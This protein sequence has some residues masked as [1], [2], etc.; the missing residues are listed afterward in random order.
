MTMPSPGAADAATLDWLAH[1][2]DRVRQAAAARGARPLLAEGFGSKRSLGMPARDGTETLSMLDYT[3]VVSFD[4]TELVVVARAGTPMAEVEALLEERHQVLAFEPPRLGGTGS[5]GGMVAMGLSGPR[6]LTAGPCRDFVLGMT[7]MNSRGEM[8]R[9][10]GTVMKNVAGYDVSR[11]HTGARGSLGIILDV[12]LKVLPRPAAEASLVFEPGAL[13]A[14]ADLLRRLNG[15]LAQPWPLAATATEPDGHVFLRL[16]GAKAA[17]AEATVHF[18]GQGAALLAEPDAH[19][20]WTGLRDRR[21]AFFSRPGALWRLSLPP[22]TPTPEPLRD[23]PRLTE[24]A[25]GQRW[26]LADL[27]AAAVRAAA[28]AAGGWAELVR[29]GAGMDTS[30]LQT[31]LA[32]EALALH[33]RLAQQL[34]PEGAFAHGRL[35]PRAATTEGMAWTHN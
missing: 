24:W 2:R 4:P 29:V 11:L 16:M 20:F 7:V 21:H 28:Q 13:G 3:G 19:R 6:R 31:P 12:A 1:A 32:A 5:I 9:F 17:V 18:Q 33:Q 8:M 14:E 26:I 30:E 15:W 34:D 35:F 25:G 22:T 23:L 10:G 27:P